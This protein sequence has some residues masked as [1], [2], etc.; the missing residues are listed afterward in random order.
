MKLAIRKELKKLLLF[1]CLFVTV[2]LS[3]GT[4]VI[5]VKAMIRVSISTRNIF[6]NT[7]AKKAMPNTAA[8]SSSIHSAVIN[9]INPSNSQFYIRSNTSNAP[10]TAFSS[11]SSSSS[12]S[13]SS[14]PCAIFTLSGVQDYFAHNAQMAVMSLFLKRNQS[15]S[16]G[17]VMK[18]IGDDASLVKEVWTGAKKGFFDLAVNG[19]NYTDYSKLSEK[20]QKDLLENANEKI[21][22]LFGE[23]SN[24]FIPPYDKFN[25]STTNALYQAGIPILSSRDGYDKIPYFIVNGNDSNT[26]STV[27]YHTNLKYIY[28]IPQMVSLD[29]YNSNNGS[30]VKVP[31]SRV[32]DGIGSSITKYGYV[33][34]NLDPQYLLYNKEG[35]GGNI[36]TDINNHSINNLLNLINYLMSKHI[37]ITSYSKLVGIEPKPKINIVQNSLISQSSLPYQAVAKSTSSNKQPLL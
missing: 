8:K 28:H 20:E 26:I 22:G 5:E 10:I 34:I 25:N 24:T 13:A 18:N 6:D 2:V 4:N 36:D 3:I 9:S 30:I 32:L 31:I 19:W 27:N 23:T 37:H 33:V 29:T 17:L 11:T 1:I 14:C 16:L 21:Q 35:G 15:L 7:I 12:S